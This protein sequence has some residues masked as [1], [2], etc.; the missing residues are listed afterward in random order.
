MTILLP[1]AVDGLEALENQI[2]TSVLDRWLADLRQEFV[3]IAL[4]RFTIDSGMPRVF[5]QRAA[6]FT[7]IADPPDPQD[8]LFINDVVHKSFVKVDEVGTEAVGATAVIMLA[9]AALREPKPRLF[10]ADHPFL[11]LIR[12]VRSRMILFIGRVTDPRS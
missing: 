9:G 1:R 5:D 11:F 6:D 2:S 3:Q 4:P 12:D 7:G 8:R 10:R